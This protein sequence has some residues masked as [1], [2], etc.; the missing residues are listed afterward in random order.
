MK[1]S[2]FKR[3]DSQQGWLEEDEGLQEESSQ[4][5]NE[6]MKPLRGSKRESKRNALPTLYYCV[7]HF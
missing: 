6:K 4:E 7:L 5:A 1:P 3:S 2:S